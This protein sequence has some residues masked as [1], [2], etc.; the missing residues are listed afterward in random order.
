MQLA[1]FHRTGFSHNE[2]VKKKGDF[3][4]PSDNKEKGEA[5]L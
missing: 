1:G 4:K 3:V 5:S 2:I